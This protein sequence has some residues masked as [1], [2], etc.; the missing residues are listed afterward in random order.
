ME[1]TN[2]MSVQ[3]VVYVL[4]GSSYVGHPISSDNGPISQ[5]VLLKSE[6]YCQL[7]VAVGVA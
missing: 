7:H 1:N 4:R 3:N 5:K 6:F 2:G